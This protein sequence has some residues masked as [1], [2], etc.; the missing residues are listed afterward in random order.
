VREYGRPF[1]DERAQAA[2]VVEV[3]VRVDHVADRLV[4]DE[5]LRFSDDGQRSWFALSRFDEGDVV[6]EIDG[7]DGVPA[8]DEIDAVTELL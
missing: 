5:P 1:G 8:G 3:A 7:D 6:L 2:G 4:R